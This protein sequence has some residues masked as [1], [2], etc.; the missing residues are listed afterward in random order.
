MKSLERELF[1][2]LKVG[3]STD[4]RV[5]HLRTD[6]QNRVRWSTL[7]QVWGQMWDQMWNYLEE[8]L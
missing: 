6:M 5:P 3:Q 7:D 1:K 8:Q 2:G 4:A